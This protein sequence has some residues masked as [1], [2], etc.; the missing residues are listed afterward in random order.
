MVLVELCANL[1]ERQFT[2]VVPQSGDML[3]STA[4][5]IYCILTPKIPCLLL[6]NFVDFDEK[7][8]S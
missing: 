1:F 5:S 2:P 3:Q 8:I 4:T 7:S 6:P